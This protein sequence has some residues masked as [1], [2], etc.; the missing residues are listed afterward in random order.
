MTLVLYERVGKQDDHRPSP[1]SWRARFALAHKGLTPE[2]TVPVRFADKEIIAFSGQGMV[3]V[4]V[5]GEAVV[6]DSWRIACY[7]ED[8]YPERPSLFGGAKGRALAE[9][10]NA[11]ADLSLNGAVFPLVIGDLFANI[12]PR[13]RDYYRSTREARFGRAIES[14]A[15]ERPTFEA[16]LAEVLTPLRQQLGANRFLCG[17]RPA[18]ADYIAFSAFQ[19]ARCASPTPL[20]AEDDPLHDWL[21]AMTDLYDGMAASL[22]RFDCGRGSA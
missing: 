7:L 17:E 15:A 19:W 1:F 3:P 4:L 13:D 6:P 2:R 20:I 9:F 18:Y 21:D 10:V 22:L 5:D 16:K 12:D 11:W 8:S 14:F